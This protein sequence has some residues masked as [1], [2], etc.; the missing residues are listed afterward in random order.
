MGVSA[1]ARASY[2]KIYSC[3]Q[4]ASFKRFYRA[5]LKKH[6]KTNKDGEFPELTRGEQEE[7]ASFWKKYGISLSSYEWHQ[8]YYGKSGIKDPRFVP[9]DVFHRL[10]RPHMNDVGLA[11]AWSDKA[12]TDW[13]VR[14]VHTVCSVVRCVNGRL[15]DGD[16]K[17]IDTKTA[18]RIMNLYDFLVIKPT[19]YTDTGKNVMLLNAPFKIEEI[20]KQY[21]KFFVVQLPMKQH[22]DLAKLNES[23]VN[24]I[25]IDTV[26]FD[27]KA[28]ATSAFIKVGQ[29]G[30]FADNG[31]GEKRIFIGI[32]DG[33]FTDFA[34]DHDCNKFYTIPSGYEFAGK[35]VPFFQEMCAAVEKAHSYI[36]HF[37]LAFW[38]VSVD[39]NGEPTIVEM[40][41]RYPDSYVPQVGSGP[42]FGNYTE[43]VLDYLC[44]K[45]RW[46]N[47]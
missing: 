45:D 25:R 6:V 17:L 44:K 8:Y 29:P 42:F 13:V 28:H 24:T 22:P 31:G 3:Y 43:E 4:N 34:F 46:G 30:Q 2:K 37:G 36:P 15:L 47:R 20:L 12:Y 33:K 19:M 39:Q 16:F 10:I 7:I 27:Q 1:I 21:G 32:R 41:L 40:N 23:S 14:D 5:D 11:A 26:L 18:G 38:D 9:D 35:K